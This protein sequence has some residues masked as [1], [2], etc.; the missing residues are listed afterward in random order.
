MNFRLQIQLDSNQQ[1]SVLL[2]SV[3]VYGSFD[4]VACRAVECSGGRDGSDVGRDLAAAGCLTITLR[5]GAVACWA[6]G[7]FPDTG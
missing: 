1:S 6:D 7:G 3:V 5:V 2:L 4:D